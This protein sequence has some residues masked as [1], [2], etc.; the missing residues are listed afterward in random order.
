M[1]LEP[2][3]GKNL[4]I[5]GPECSGGSRRADAEQRAI[6]R[7]KNDTVEDIVWITRRELKH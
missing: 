6:L 2:S 1:W 4:A 3:D 5:A 7:S